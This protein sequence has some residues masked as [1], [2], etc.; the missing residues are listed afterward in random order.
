[1]LWKIFR[2]L[3]YI[4]FFFILSVILVPIIF[5]SMR[6][7][8]SL[9]GI[10]FLG[11]IGNTSS[12]D[13]YISLVSIFLSIASIIISVVLVYYIQRLTDVKEDYELKQQKTK[14]YT[15]TL[16]SLK[17]ALEG[18]F[19]RITI[20]DS[21]ISE[22]VILHG[23]LDDAEVAVL[24]DIWNI[25]INIKMLKVVDVKEQI[26]ALKRVIYVSFF[27]LIDKDKVKNYLSLMN[28]DVLKILNKLSN[29]KKDTYEYGV[30]YYYDNSPLF[31][32]Y[33]V[34]G[35]ER[36][37]VYFYNQLKY[38][39]SFDGK[40][41]IN[42]FGLEEN[43]K[44]YYVGNFKNMKR[45]G[46]GELFYILNSNKVLLAKGEWSDGSIIN[47]EVHNIKRIYS[48]TS[49]RFDYFFDPGIIDNDVCKLIKVYSVRIEN[50]QIVDKFNI[51][52]RYEI[53]QIK[54]IKKIALS[55]AGNMSVND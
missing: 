13:I 30:S 22:S 38:D 11:E 45:H 2:Y 25:L 1:M 17:N 43:D 15:Q 24:T 23:F 33:I 7:L 41:P 31:K 6:Y 52:D 50:G 16:I 20:T 12:L 19:D 32:S 28:K 26:I 47:G 9:T 40:N 5:I 53:D 35:E 39:C 21:F 37:K 4:L 34:E 29:S 3:L 14:F 51:Q 18:K 48:S 36:F 42:G 44:V 49:L 8:I 27:E 46:E 54:A 55:I 10:G